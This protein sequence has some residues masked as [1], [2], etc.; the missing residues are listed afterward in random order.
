MAL[1]KQ[2]S[3]VKPEPIEEGT[4]PAYVV[5]IIDVGLQ[6]Q[7]DFQTGESKGKKPTIRF[8]FELPTETI[9]VDGEQ[10][11]RWLS[12]AYTYSV[13][14]N[15]NYYIHEKSGLAKLIVA[16]GNK[17]DPF[18]DITKLLKCSLMCN[19]GVTTG[20]N[21]KVASTTK[22][23]KGYPKLPPLVNTPIVFDLDN[24]DMAVYSTFPKFLKEQI[25]LETESNSEEEDLP[26]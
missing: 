2:Q 20:G 11:P 21:N 16:C 25:G 19:V 26:F 14:K 17:Y 12:K 6:E 10:K 22:L 9:E 3:R 13:S 7:T 4:Y 15:G 18:F 5:Q 23:P 1:L 24:P 8:T